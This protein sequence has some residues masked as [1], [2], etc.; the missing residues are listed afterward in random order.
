MSGV[1][2]WLA[3]P[4]ETAQVT[5]LMLGFRDDLGYHWPSDQQF[6]EGIAQLAGDAQTD[7]LL[8]ALDDQGPPVGVCQLRFRFGLWR[9]GNDCWLEDLYVEPQ[10]RGNGLGRALTEFAVQHA[11]HAR[12][13]QR[14]ELDLDEANET[15]LK[16]Y[17]SLGFAPKSAG[18]RDLYLRRNLGSRP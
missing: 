5:R 3:G 11:E 1:R 7:Y 17:S 12:G 8:G 10:A 14:I 18:S 4:D 15:A 6:S 13:C 9:G 2:V 16:L